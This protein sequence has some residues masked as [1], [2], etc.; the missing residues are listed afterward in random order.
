MDRN[1]IGCLDRRIDLRVL[2]LY[3]IALRSSQHDPGFLDSLGVVVLETNPGATAE[4]GCRD[5]RRV[6]GDDWRDALASADYGRSY[7]RPVRALR[8]RDAASMPNSTR[9]ESAGAGRCR[10]RSAALAGGTARRRRPARRANI[11]RIFFW[12][13]KISGRPMSWPTYYLRAII[14]CRARRPASYQRTW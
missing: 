3:P 8:L 12:T 13:N 6:L 14:H 2:A 11:R 1:T 7:H 10:S 5:R 4:A 9:G